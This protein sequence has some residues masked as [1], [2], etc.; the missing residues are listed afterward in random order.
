MFRIL[1]AAALLVPVFAAPALARD[2]EK[3]FTHEGITYTY[4]AT[5]TDDAVVLEGIAK[6]TGGRFRFVV[7]NGRVTGYAGNVRVNFLVADVMKD[8]TLARL[9]SLTR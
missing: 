4:T 3:T 2:G 7:R 6:P 9:A 1:F 8:K 5:R